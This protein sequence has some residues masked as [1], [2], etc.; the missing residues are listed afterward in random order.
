MTD[1]FSLKGRIALV[2][3]AWRGLGLAVPN[4]PFDALVSTQLFSKPAGA[5][6]PK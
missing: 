3:G 2:T 5:F 4:H 1:R 6:G